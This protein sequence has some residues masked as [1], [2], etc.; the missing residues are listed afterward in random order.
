MAQEH[1]RD[2]VR[3][4]TVHVIAL[5]PLILMQVL[6]ARAVMLKPSRLDVSLQY[7]DLRVQKELCDRS[8]GRARRENRLK[9][10]FIF[11]VI[12]SPGRLI[13]GFILL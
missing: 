8:L 2:A 10:I 6:L 1:H 9:L 12:A 5:V 3:V 11:R 13:E 7:R 4:L